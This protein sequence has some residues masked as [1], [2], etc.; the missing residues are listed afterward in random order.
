[1]KG[2][3]IDP[4][5]VKRRHESHAGQLRSVQ[6]YRQGGPSIFDDGLEDRRIQTGVP[7]MDQHVVPQPIDSGE[8]EQKA[9]GDIHDRA[10]SGAVLTCVSSSLCPRF[11]A[12]VP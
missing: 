9:F 12:P 2:K 4:R 11:E 5:G 10:V 8:G 1:M 7:Q 3:S 6:S